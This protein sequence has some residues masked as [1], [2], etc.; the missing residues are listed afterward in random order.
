L[1]LLPFEPDVHRR[2]SGPP[3]TY[4]GHPLAEAIARLRPS[5]DEANR[6]LMMP[7]KLLLLPGSR[8]G[9]L[10]RFLA[11]FM[12]V[13]ALVQD[14]I[15]G[16]DVVIP[17][18]PH[19]ADEIE[20]RSQQC[21]VKARIILDKGEK[22]AAFRTATAALAKSG[23]VTLELA[24][25]G[26]PMVTAY[27]VSALEAV[28]GRRIVRRIPSII[29]ANL[30]LGENIVPE[31]LQQECTP[32]KLAAGLLPLLVDSPERTRQLAAFSRLDS[33]MQTGGEPPAA[34][35]ADVVIQVIE[36]ASGGHHARWSEASL[37]LTRS[38]A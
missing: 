33:I 13:A 24:L 10:Q 36:R 20:T 7:P 30:V 34:R 11:I 27:K 6:R 31:L 18:M 37:S 5:C 25:A 2:L 8:F 22:E 1:A 14:R 3:C 32:E 15:G 21:R 19:L 9:E 29:L 4:V 35:A 38:G 26:V 23:T 17:T 16:L 12:E 28:V